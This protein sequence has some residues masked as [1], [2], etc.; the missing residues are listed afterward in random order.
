MIGEDSRFDEDEIQLTS[1]P[2]QPDR[3]KMSIPMPEPVRRAFMAAFELHRRR[4]GPGA[5]IES[6]L[7]DLTKVG[8]TKTRS[9]Q[10][11]P[12]PATRRRR[13]T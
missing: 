1:I 9:S 13:K 4:V 6:F 5:T 11:A 10:P 3:V 2:G 8:R 7:E 12:H